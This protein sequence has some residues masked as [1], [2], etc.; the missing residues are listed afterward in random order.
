MPGYE[1]SDRHALNTSSVGAVGKYIKATSTAPPTKENSDEI[2]ELM[3][4]S[5]EE[6]VRKKMK[7]ADRGGDFGNFDGW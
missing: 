6:H 7:S 5:L 4:G 2:T 3:D 1:T